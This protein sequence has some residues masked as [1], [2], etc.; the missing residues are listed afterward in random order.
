MPEK[1]SQGQADKAAAEQR[2]AQVAAE[3]KQQERD[4]GAKP[5]A[6]T[7][8]ERLSAADQD[9]MPDV[10]VD[11]Y[12][13]YEDKSVAEL[14]SAAEGRGVEINRDVEKA[15]LVQ[16]IRA[17]DPTNAALDF[18]TL[19]DLRSLASEKDVE[20]DDEFVKAHLITELRAAD[21]GVSNPGRHVL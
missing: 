20:L 7:A 6:A 4:A 16:R 15:E 13:P 10:A 1:V 18:M 12:P 17:K 19:E 21:T 8:A 14:R 2:T 9:T 5:D 3:N 11:P